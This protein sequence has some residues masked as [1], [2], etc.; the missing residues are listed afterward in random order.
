MNMSWGVTP[1]LVEEKTNTDELFKH[2]IT[3][4]HNAGLLS[5]GDLTVITAGVPLGKSGTTNMIRI[6]VVG[7]EI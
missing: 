2:A 1:L 7:E 4:A 5:D 3:A 6:H